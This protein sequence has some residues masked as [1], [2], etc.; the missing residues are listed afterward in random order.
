MYLI[1]KLAKDDLTIKDDLNIDIKDDLNI[2]ILMD[3][4]LF[5]EMHIKI[6]KNINIGKNFLNTL[7]E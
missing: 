5:I 7:E 3:K 2:D 4:N 1:L 6:L